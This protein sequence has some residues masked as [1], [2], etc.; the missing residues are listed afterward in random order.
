MTKQA[1]K[2][3]LLH[4]WD[5]A[6]ERYRLI[7]IANFTPGYEDV[8]VIELLSQDALGEPTWSTIFNWRPERGKVTI[9]SLLIAAL[10]TL[11]KYC[12]G[13]S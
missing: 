1:S 13:A 12:G 10:K 3:T 8:Y 9:E 6:N 11:T 2:A 5:V 7:T 4:E